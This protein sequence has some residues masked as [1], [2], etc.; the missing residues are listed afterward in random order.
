MTM[1]KLLTIVCLTCALALAA[2]AGEGKGKEGKK[3]ERPTAEQK[4]ARKAL[5]EKYDADKSGKLSKEELAKATAE[6]REKAG[7]A[8]KKGEAKKA[9]K[10]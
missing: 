3:R 10:N 8:K 5:V 2:Q 9:E 6:E 7:Y 4:A 1:K